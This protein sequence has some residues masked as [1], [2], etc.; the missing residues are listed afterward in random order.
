MQSHEN[1]SFPKIFIV[2]NLT[3]IRG[4]I[5]YLHRNNL[6]H[7]GIF[8]ET[9]KMI[10]LEIKKYIMKFETCKTR[11]Q[12]K[13]TVMLLIEQI[14]TYKRDVT[15]FKRIIYSD[16]A[17]SALYISLFIFEIHS[18]QISRFHLSHIV[19]NIFIVQ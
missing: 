14:K 5:D 11:T 1:C 15:I 19:Y 7:I 4:S 10:S 16:I 8:G 9:L 18:Q 6:V 17:I 3:V 2:N 12:P 13:I